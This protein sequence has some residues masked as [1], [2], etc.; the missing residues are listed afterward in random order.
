MCRFFSVSIRIY[1][2]FPAFGAGAG[3]ARGGL[4]FLFPRRCTS[5]SRA[6][7]AS[8]SH[9]HAVTA[10]H[11]LAHPRRLLGDEFLQAHFAALHHVQRLFPDGGGAGV[12]DGAGHCVNQAERGRG[13]RQGLAV[14]HQI[15][16]V[17]QA[18][19]DPGAGG[20]GA[21]ASGVLEFLLEQRVL[22]QL[23]DVFSWP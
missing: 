12:G 7:G 1:R 8:D 13:C 10:C 4:A 2:L 14:F 11:L 18:L 15:T 17:Q 5:S 21:D 23:G 3:L 9:A 20:L 6:G 19:D 16:A 22:H